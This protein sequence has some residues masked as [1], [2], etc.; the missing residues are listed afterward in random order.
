[1]STL[2]DTIQ[3]NRVAGTRITIWDVFLY[4]DAGWSA[5]RIAKELRLTRDQVQAAIDFIAEHREEVEA[6]HRKIEARNARGN[7][8]EIEAK[9]A[10][11]RKRMNEWL[12]RRRAGNPG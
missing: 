8:P 6:G 3:N 10:E 4:L 11:T 7:P 9:R 12:E 1:M 5:E 2:S